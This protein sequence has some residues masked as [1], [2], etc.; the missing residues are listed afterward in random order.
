[1]QTNVTAGER[2]GRENVARLSAAYAEERTNGATERAAAAATGV[3]RSTHRDWVE[4]YARIDAPDAEK[5]FFESAAGVAFLHRLVTALHLVIIFNVG[6]GIRQVTLVLDLVKLTAFVATSIGVHGGIAHAMEAQLVGY[7]KQERERLAKLM[8]P[9]DIVVCQDETFHPETCLVAIEPVS[10]FVLAEKYVEHRDAE[11]W[12]ATMKEALGGLPVT[13]R[14]STSDEGAGILS[15]ARANKAHHSSDLFHIQHETSQAMSLGLARRVNAA[16]DAV[17]VADKQSARVTAQKVE[18]ETTAHGPGRPPNFHRREADAEAT[19]IAANLALDEARRWQEAARKARRGLSRDY[20]PVDIA[21]G[22]PRTAEVVA[23]KLRE[24]FDALETIAVDA[25]LP[26]T[27]MAG[28]QK[29]ERQLPTLKASLHFFHEQVAKRVKALELPPE[30]TDAV[31]N[32]LIPA[33]YLERAANRAQLA[34]DKEALRHTA[35]ERRSTGLAALIVAGT[36]QAQRDKLLVLAAECA[37]MFQRTSSCVEGRNGQLSLRHHHLHD[38]P[39]MRLEALTVIHN[40]F[41]R[42]PDGTTAAQRFFGHKPA[43]LFEH[44][45]STAPSAPRPAAKRPPAVTL[46]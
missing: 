4:R 12:N 46:H 43:D 32:N 10:N 39:P 37:D 23:A 25:G 2:W 1:M 9:K 44:L 40:Y 35:H 19:L 17:E 22:E 14:Q 16:N 26:H 36:D 45:L 21:T 29:A 34:D 6:A 42:R 15:H 41:I 11:T 31:Q 3:P 18:Y 38:I 5:V 7:G 8:S 28:L 20:H 30:Q 27:S 33:A 24:H 13:M